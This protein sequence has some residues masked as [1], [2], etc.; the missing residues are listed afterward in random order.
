M[1]NVLDLALVRTFVA[2]AEHAGMTAAGNALHLTQSAVS[3]Q[4]KR[5][6][7]SLGTPLFIRDRRGLR[8]TRTGE[9][10]RSRAIPLLALNDET[11]SEMSATG[12]SGRVRVGVP[13]DLVGNAFS[14]ILKTYV[15]AHPQVEVSL[16]SGSSTDLKKL[17]LGGGIDLAIVEEPSSLS[18]SNC[19]GVERLVWAGAKQGR[20]YR[21]KP[22][23]VSMVSETCAFRPV[24]I[25]ALDKA[26]RDWR[27]VFENVSME[28]TAATTR[29]DLAVSVWLE[30]YAPA[31]LEI[32]GPE[33]G[34]PRLPS[35]AINLYGPAQ[36]ASPA[37]R[38]FESHLRDGFMRERRKL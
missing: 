24:V 7:E 23:P 22:L 11:I 3:Q 15:E 20:A 18:G 28:A 27:T 2:V 10:F 31:D 33:C 5:L 30:I 32:L 12:P 14:A 1:I 37:V 4:I 13:L 26:R 17:A 29:A 9:R 19:L 25:E 21:K 8:L 34:V 38:S 35:F 16:L 36:N 6:E